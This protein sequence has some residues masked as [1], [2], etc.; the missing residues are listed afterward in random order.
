VIIEAT[1][2][3]F[4]LN[5]GTYYYAAMLPTNFSLLNVNNI[6]ANDLESNQL[7]SAGQFP[8][9]YGTNYYD[10]SDNPKNT[11]CCDFENVTLSGMNYSAF[12][13]DLQQNVELFV[14]NYNASGTP[15][16]LFLVP[17]TDSICYNVT[18]CVGQFLLP[19]SATPYSFYALSQFPEYEYDI[20]IDGVET[21][22]FPRTA[23]PYN[24]TV[25]VREIFSGLPEEDAAVL[26][27]EDSGQ[28]L[29]VPFTLAGY[30]TE[31]YA[32]GN[33]N[34]QGFET[35][36]VTPTV[37]PSIVNYSIYVAVYLDDTILSREQLFVTEQDSLVA[38][39]KTFQPSRLQDNAVASV[40]AMNQIVSFMFTWSSQRIEAFLFN[41]DYNVGLDTFTTF[42]LQV[43]AFV[44]NPIT[45]K[46]G[47]PNVISVDILNSGL[48]PP[49]DY[50]VR[51]QETDGYLIMNPYT[52]NSPLT[53]TDRRHLR[54]APVSTQFI[55]TP[56]SLGFVNS[57]ITLE[58]L[59]SSDNVIGTTTIPVNPS[60]NIDS[61]GSFYNNDLLKTIVNLMN[62]IVNNM[63][64]SLN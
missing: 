57:T 19:V 42:D 41:I 8:N 63:F 53:E 38:T 28:N 43:S 37:Y 9:F 10:Y 18:A 31:N 39:P 16:P 55:V 13:I 36:L 1:F 2:P 23:L 58:V 52:D 60:L 3:G 59:D 14:L 54:A 27:G 32:I 26:V 62:Q 45:L 6:T 33:T 64:N 22:T 24:L 30:I 40:N 11:F 21:N 4:N 46:T 29:F 49:N 56:T 25:L 48:T 17:F 34:A 47:A 20:F 50:S 15:T 35:F 7:F 61:S 12:K 5:D 51:I 44:S